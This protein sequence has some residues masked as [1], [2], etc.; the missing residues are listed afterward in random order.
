[1]PGRRLPAAIAI[2]VLAGAVATGSWVWLRD[3]PQAAERPDV[4]F[5]PLVDQAL[6]DP[7]NPTKVFRVDFARVEHE[8]PLAR[9]DLMKL[10]PANIRTLQQEEM[11]QIYGRLTAGPIPDGPYRGDLF[12]ARGESLRPRLEEILGGI[13]GRITG[14]KVELLERV[15]RSLWKGKLFDREQLVLRNFIEDFK[16]L[17]PLIDDPSA[18]MTAEVPR[19]GLLGRILPTTSVWLLFPAK[20]F[21]GQSLLDSRRESV[22]IDYLYGDEIEGY[23]ASPDS[24]A[25]RGGLRIRD[26]IRMVRPGFYL[27]RA[28]ANRAFLLNFTLYNPEVADAGTEAFAR[29]EPIAEDCW[30]GEQNRQPVRRQVAAQ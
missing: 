4:P 21:C 10:T 11:D 3:D 20:L 22:I 9:A 17:E 8:F 19:G 30:P 7:D 15:G 24:L 1:M 29:G 14:T 12:F 25:G 13:G 16:P 5:A 23:Q 26:E 2:V 27:G 6:K 18:L 28:Y